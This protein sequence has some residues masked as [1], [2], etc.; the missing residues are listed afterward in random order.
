MFLCSEEQCCAALFGKINAG[1]L[2]FK[3]LEQARVLFFETFVTW[4]A[5]NNNLALANS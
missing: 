4:A 1:C 2:I 3:M 5:S